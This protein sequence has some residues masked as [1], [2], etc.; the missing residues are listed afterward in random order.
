MLG[1]FGSWSRY[2]FNPF[3]G[4]LN[5]IFDEGSSHTPYTYFV[6]FFVCVC[7]CVC[8][9]FK[10]N[11]IFLRFF[12]EENCEA[13]FPLAFKVAEHSFSGIAF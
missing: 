11:Y 12:R 3:F 6:A 10:L 1:L 9:F 8:V 13:N 7:A 5:W 4:V 2:F